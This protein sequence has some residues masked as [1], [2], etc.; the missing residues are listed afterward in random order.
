MREK[1]D[2]KIEELKLKIR[3]IDIGYGGIAEFLANKL[4]EKKDE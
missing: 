2:K 4:K 3:V 1:K